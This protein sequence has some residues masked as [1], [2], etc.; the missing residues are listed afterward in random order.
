MADR[1]LFAQAEV[2]WVATPF[3]HAVS[4]SN[5]FVGGISVAISFPW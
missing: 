2:N 5:R 4:L 1:N 3:I